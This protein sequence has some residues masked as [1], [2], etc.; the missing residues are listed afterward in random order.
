MHFSIKSELNNTLLVKNK[1]DSKTIIEFQNPLIISDYSINII[2]FFL[3]F[4]LHLGMNFSIIIEM[5]RTLLRITFSF[6]EQ[7]R[8]VIYYE[9][10]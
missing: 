10:T 6:G 9:I 2:S 4:V 3:H 7:K 5:L 8:L 1:I